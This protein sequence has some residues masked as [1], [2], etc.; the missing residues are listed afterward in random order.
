VR[1]KKRKKKRRPR[2]IYKPNPPRVI[3]R[4]KQQRQI[5]VKWERGKMWEAELKLK[6]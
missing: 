4:S 3:G 2:K 6:Y 1:R 5:S